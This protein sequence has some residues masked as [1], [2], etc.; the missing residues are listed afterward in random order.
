MATVW[1]VAPT[2][3]VRTTNMIQGM[4]GG[5]QGTDAPDWFWQAWV[6]HLWVFLSLSFI[7]NKMK[8]QVTT[9]DLPFQLIITGQQS[10]SVLTFSLTNTNNSMECPVMTP[11]RPDSQ[12]GKRM[13]IPSITCISVEVKLFC[14][15]YPNLGWGVSRKNP[16]NSKGAKHNH[17]SSVPQHLKHNIQA[18]ANTLGQGE[19]EVR[20]GLVLSIF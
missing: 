17:V 15:K 20:E 7:I 18:D 1:G 16:R 2:E 11:C 13:R 14:Y 3:F 8:R 6:S 10:R 4:S 12:A 5:N 9:K 19:S